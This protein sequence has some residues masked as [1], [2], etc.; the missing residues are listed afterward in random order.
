MSTSYYC[1]FMLQEMIGFQNAQNETSIDLA[2]VIKTRGLR[3]II[4]DAIQQHEYVNIKMGFYGISEPQC[5]GDFGKF[6]YK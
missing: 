6:L 1:N 2:N 5:R 4:K 3:I